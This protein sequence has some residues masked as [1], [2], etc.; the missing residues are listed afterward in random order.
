MAF[1]EVFTGSVASGD[2][3]NSKRSASVRLVPAKAR[4][5]FA[6]ADHAA[7]LATDVGLLL[8]SLNDLQYS[9]GGNEIFSY[10]VHHSDEN[11]AY[12]QPVSPPEVYNK[13]RIRITVSTTNGG[14]PALDQIYVPQRD[15]STYTTS[16]GGKTLDISASPF[17]NIETQLMATGLSKFNTPILGIVEAVPDDV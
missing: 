7:R 8:Q 9:D 16:S 13:N 17:P 5:W 6:A 3:T 15:P 12:S 2:I 14:L 10:D 11:G 4:L 1:V